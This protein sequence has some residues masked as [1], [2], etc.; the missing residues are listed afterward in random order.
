MKIINQTQDQM[1]LKDGNISSL[2]AGVVLM[3]VGVYI[4]YQT[5]SVSGLSKNVLVGVGLFIFGLVVLFLSSAITIS[6]DKSQNKIL[7]LKK[8]LLGGKSQ[9]YAIQD[10]LRVE[11]RK[12]IEMEQGTRSQTGTISMPHQV[13]KYQS[14]IIFKDGVELPLENVKNSSGITSGVLMGVNG[15][16]IS[17]ANQIAA[18]LNVPFQEG[19]PASASTII[20]PTT[21]KMNL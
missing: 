1:S 21:G 7:F 10:V 15:K 2:V 3:I 13:L 6:I 14:I 19:N 17:I 5:Y 12:S 4:F 18:F 8:R 20:P 11:L 16:E 9:T